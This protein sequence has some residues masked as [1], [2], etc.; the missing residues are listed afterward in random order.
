MVLMKNFL[1]AVTIISLVLLLTYYAGY[2]QFTSLEDTQPNSPAT[3]FSP[4]YYDLKTEEGS[5]RFNLVDPETAPAEI[6]DKVM[7]GF[8][9]VCETPTYAKEYTGDALKC[10][11]CHFSCGNSFGGEGGG[12]S[13]VGVVNAY[14]AYSE[15]N[16]R[17]ISLK[18]RINNC[19]L[20]SMNGKAIPENGVLMDAIIAYLDW[21]SKPVSAIKKAPWLG[22]PEITVHHI[23]NPVN[24]K[25]VYD[26]KCASCHKDDGNG[27]SLK[28]IPPVWG[29]HSFN[30]V[31][32]MNKLK[33]LSSFVHLNMPYQEPTL[34]ELESLDVAA[35]IIA[36]PRP[37]YIED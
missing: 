5:V 22:L 11:H 20:K 32:G 18:Q 6:Y 28:D 7:L 13:L 9:I 16:K 8:N 1:V 25:A 12:L 34:D 10:T 26:L 14:P 37:I 31:A 3:T 30:N 19:F 4:L 21:I 33:T 36:Q 17:V 29:D 2:K 35:Y 23:P 24:G 15:W 27:D